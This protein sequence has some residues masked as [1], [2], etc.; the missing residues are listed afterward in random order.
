MLFDLGRVVI[1]ANALNQLQEADVLMALAL[2]VTGHW[3][4]V[5][6]EDWQENQRSLEHGWR[7]LSVYTDSNQTKFWIITEADRAATTVLLPEDY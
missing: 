6:E 1:T 7:L 3:G 2:H 5:D 4:E